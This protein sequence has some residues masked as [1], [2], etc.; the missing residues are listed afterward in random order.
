MRPY[1]RTS[2]RPELLVLM[3]ETAESTGLG[4]GGIVDAHHLQIM[5]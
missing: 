5:A 1:L 3:S 4:D 2:A